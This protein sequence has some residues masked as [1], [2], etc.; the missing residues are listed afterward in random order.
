MSRVKVIEMTWFSAPEAVI[1]PDTLLTWLRQHYPAALPVRFGPGDPPSLTLKT[2]GMEAF[3]SQW[4]RMEDAHS[5]M[6]W[7]GS[8]P[9]LRG[10][11]MFPGRASDRRNGM[12][13]GSMAW[14]LDADGEKV[15]QESVADL[16]VG[17]ATLLDAFYAC[18]H[19]LDGWSWTN[20]VLSANVFTS[21]MSRVAA[22]G[23]WLGIPQGHAWITWFGRPYRD[24]VQLAA[25]YSEYDLG[26]LVL[27]PP[28]PE[29]LAPYH[30]GEDLLARWSDPTDQRFPPD[31][32]A[33]YLPRL[34]EPR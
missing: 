23:H 28:D 8:R 16:L 6:Q 32:P 7:T 26:V 20:G 25:G 18:A 21:Q 3:A 14:Y 12:P 22:S 11:R 2:D 24:A 13:A 30:L 19:V 15:N 34:G 9:F 31:I 5:V 33:M 4:H 10:A 1:E 17:V 29:G 27:A